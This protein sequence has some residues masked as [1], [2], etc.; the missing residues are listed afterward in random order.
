MIQS[1]VDAN[2][3]IIVLR[4]RLGG[5]RKEKHRYGRKGQR[6][7]GFS[8]NLNWS[9]VLRPRHHLASSSD[10][11]TNCDSPSGL[12]IDWQLS[13][14]HGHSSDRTLFEGRDWPQYSRT[15]SSDHPL[16]H[17]WCCCCQ[18]TVQCDQYVRRLFYL[19]Y[20]LA[21]CTRSRHSLLTPIPLG[22]E[23]IIHECQWPPDIPPIT[24]ESDL[25]R[26]KTQ[27]VVNAKINGS[28]SMVQFSR[29]KVPG[30]A[31]VLQLLGLV[32]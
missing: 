3:H 18:P 5:K 9:C 14:H 1:T 19:L 27:L 15:P 22:F 28:R 12:F 26:R 6:G 8:A 17:S 32:R 30:P 25:A 2:G 21:L 31:W 16:H 11:A 29:D 24:S 20:P 23:S 10:A 13:L 4:S 7:L